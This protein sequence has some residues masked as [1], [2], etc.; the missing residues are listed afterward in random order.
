[1]TDSSYEMPDGMTVH[2]ERK[3]IDEVKAARK[4]KWAWARDLV[5][6][7]AGPGKDAIGFRMESVTIAGSLISMLQRANLR[8]T[9][10][11]RGLIL[12]PTQRLRTKLSGKTAWA[13]IEE[14]EPRY[15]R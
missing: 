15:E 14:C 1:M 6:K 12:P 10:K 3:P 11:N 7:E 5:L 8:P 2:I 9:T 13:W 4:S